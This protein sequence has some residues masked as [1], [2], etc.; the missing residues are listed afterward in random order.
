MLV[1]HLSQEGNYAAVRPSGTEPKLKFYLFA[2]R[3]LVSARDLPQARR[4]AS[5]QLAQMQTDLSRAA[6]GST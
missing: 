3:R 1:F 6:D 4:A 5:E 2:Y